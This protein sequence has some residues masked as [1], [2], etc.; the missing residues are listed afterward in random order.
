MS[1]P[2]SPRMVQG[3]PTDAPPDANADVPPVALQIMAHHGLDPEFVREVAEREARMQDEH[4]AGYLGDGKPPASDDYV[5]GRVDAALADADPE[6]AVITL[7][8]D[9]AFLGEARKASGATRDVVRKRLQK[10]GITRASVDEAFAIPKATPRPSKP[11]GRADPE[12]A[13][14]P[15]DTGQLLGDLRRAVLAHVVVPEKAGTAIALWVMHT[16]ALEAAEYTPRLALTSPTKRCGKST[17]LDLLDP[18]CSK[19]L[20]TSNVSAAALYRIVEAGRPTLLVDESD[21]FLG[22]AQGVRNVLNAGYQRTGQVL[23]CVGENFEPT[24]FACFAA[25]AIASIGALPGTVADR[26]ITVQ[27][28]RKVSGDSTERLN[29][30]ARKHLEAFRPRLARWAADSMPKLENADPAMPERLNDR[31]R[32][33]CGPLVA[34]ADLAG[35]SWPV[36]A[37]AAL[38]ALCA[39]NEG[40]AADVRERALAAVWTQYQ[41]G[42]EFIPLREL[43]DEMNADESA[44]WAT[45]VR[46]RPLDT[47]TLARWLKPFGAVSRQHRI[48]HPDGQGEDRPRGYFR[49]DLEP[50]AQR[51]LAAG[52]AP[53]RDTEPHQDKRRDGVTASATADS[54]SGNGVTPSG[55]PA[56]WHA[57]TPSM[58]EGEAVA[59]RVEAMRP[60]VPLKGG[61]PYLKARPAAKGGPGLCPSCGD[62]SPAGTRCGPC[63]EAAQRVSAE[64]RRIGR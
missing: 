58:G 60:Q 64:G 59:W 62:P 48:A 29:R 17:V 20:R 9:P 57:V 16:W 53:A 30:A 18:L 13:A 19:S 31:Q 8:R 22:D 49:A 52:G 35:G 5:I 41:D 6:R 47:G 42:A 2:N 34:I 1:A 50:I 54:R 7:L 40:D 56:E 63:I 32:D 61:M 43:V 26:S 15:Q 46:G 37:R 23:R 12:P 38:V 55:T 4:A 33:V 36:E 10:I 28:A 45:A 11:I 39:A 51:Y 21:S 25:V 44:G 27:M 3:T 24:P 14:E